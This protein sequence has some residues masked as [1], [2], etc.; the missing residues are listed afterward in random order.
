M[1]ESR[2][3]LNAS[4]VSTLL[5]CLWLTAPS[6]SAQTATPAPSG[7]P[8]ATTPAATTPAATTPTAV[9]AA[10]GSAPA[11]TTP[12]PTV[13]GSSPEGFSGAAVKP[14]PVSQ[15]IADRLLAM[16]A[17]HGL[18]A[19]E[20]AVRAIANSKQLAAKRSEI[21]AASS[22]VDT[23]NAGYMPALKLS[24]RY[25]RLSK[26]NNAFPLF[27]DQALVFSTT[28]AAPGQVQTSNLAAAEID[29]EFPVPLNQ[30]ALTATLDV[31]LSD[32]LLRVSHGVEAAKENREAAVLNERAVQLAVARDARVA[33]YEWIRAQ[34]T[35]FVGNQAV[36]QAR[37]HL[38]DA[39]HAFAAGIISRADV[40][41][42]KSGLK[43]AE[44]FQKRT[45]SAVKITTD[46]LRIMMGDPAT[47]NYG[48]GENILQARTLAPVDE[49][50]AV[51]EAQ[52]KRIELR[53]LDKSS[54]ALRAQTDLARAA[55][56]PRLDAQ[57]RAQLSNPNERYFIPDEKFHATWD[58]SVVLSWTPT[59]LLGADAATSELVA[60]AKVLDSQRLELQEALRLEV[61]N[62]LGNLEN[63]TFAVGASE[64]QVAASE[65]GYRARGDLFRAGRATSLEVVDAE[66]E[67][68][69]SR[70]D[71][72]NAFVDLRIA[73][74]QLEHV[75]GRD[76]SK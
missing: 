44:L 76:S 12:T 59:D 51:L 15:A 58:V 50:S 31:P 13:A 74:V 32:Y 68:T 9:P 6:V 39:E 62:A 38:A 25:T 46:R 11:S 66:T 61:S 60:R 4:T 7:M 71:V 67:L 18:K 21:T 52:N 40:M 24:A 54:R 28:P 16:Q 56:Y 57:G 53:V 65:E 35:E 36:E 75:L 42:A 69:R 17:G 63:A 27:G 70:L 26:V 45:Q 64:E 72:V 10:A 14:G 55:N 73:Q 49:A 8:S 29:F 30:F 19:D 37:G 33:Y 1:I 41:R 22:A 34:G 2:R 20:V 5:A 3:I 47:T 23:A 48:V 43:S